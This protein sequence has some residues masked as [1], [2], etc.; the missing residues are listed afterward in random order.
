MFIQNKIIVKTKG[1]ID[2]CHPVKQ[3][4]FRSTYSFL[5]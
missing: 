1:K 2:E 4:E 3:A 5:N